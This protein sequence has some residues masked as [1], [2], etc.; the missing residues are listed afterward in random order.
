MEVIFTI[1]F[2]LVSVWVSRLVFERLGFPFILGE[3]LVGMVI[4]PPILGLLGDPGS[5]SFFI[6]T[7]SMDLLAELGMFFLMFY[8]GLATDPKELGSRVKSF[9]G[10]S[11]F[12]TFAPLILGTSIAWVFTNDF[13]V[14][15]LIGL[16]ISGTSLVTKSRI[17]DD[18]GL[19]RTKI[20]H[21]MMGGGWLVV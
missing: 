12:G 7:G 14:S 13:W 16:A 21:S 18:L 2:I 8:A 5:G 6:W 3:L 20:G 10:I 4:G 11:I 9:L 15:I 1:L 19:L 17:L